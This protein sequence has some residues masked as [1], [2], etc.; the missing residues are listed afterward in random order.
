MQGL[1]THIPKLSD[2]RSSSSS[3]FFFP[4]SCLVV[5]SHISQ[6]AMMRT[7]RVVFYTYTRAHKRTYTVLCLASLAPVLSEGSLIAFPSSPISLSKPS[8]IQY[9]HTHSHS[10]THTLICHRGTFSSSSRPRKSAHQQH[11][12]RHTTHRRTHTHTPNLGHP[13]SRGC[14]KHLSQ[15]YRQ[16]PAEHGRCG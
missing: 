15:T 6:Q 14:Y 12:T 10:H 7:A 2:T 1:R 5:S 8:T 16:S 4:S 9:T 3:A 11:H 13:P